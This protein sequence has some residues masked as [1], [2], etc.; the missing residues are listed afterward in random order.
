[1]GHVHEPAAAGVAKVTQL[2]QLVADEQIP[3]PLE[4]GTQLFFESA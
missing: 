3:H 1:M 4:Q 2:L